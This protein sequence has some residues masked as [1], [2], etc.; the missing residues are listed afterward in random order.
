MIRAK[1]DEVCDLLLRKNIAYGNA[2]LDPVR[3]FSD[4]SAEDGLKVR[5]DDKLS[6]IRNSGLNDLTED[7]LLDIIGYLI[8]L[9]VSTRGKYYDGKEP[10]VCLHQGHSMIKFN[11]VEMGSDGNITDCYEKSFDT[12]DGLLDFFTVIQSGPHIIE[13]YGH[14]RQIR[15]KRDVLP[16]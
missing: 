13:L 3:V 11:V 10:K 12:I 15:I 16:F 1:C 14:A 2:A 5:I 7:T 8:L 9:S 6:R 4:L